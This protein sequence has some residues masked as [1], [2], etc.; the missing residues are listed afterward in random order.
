MTSRAIAERLVI[1]V[2]TVDN[3][4]QHVYCKL[5]VTGRSQLGVIFDVPEPAA[6]DSPSE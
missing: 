3:A 6:H 1:S 5:G 2:R 4:L